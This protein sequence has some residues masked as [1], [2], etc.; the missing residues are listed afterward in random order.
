MESGFLDIQSEEVDV[1]LNK[2]KAEYQIVKDKSF[3]NLGLTMVAKLL[4]GSLKR[5]H[6]KIYLDIF[7]NKPKAISVLKDIIISKLLCPDNYFSYIIPCKDFH[8]LAVKSYL[9]ETNLKKINNSK[10]NLRIDH[11]QF[12]MYSILYQ[13]F[14]MHSKNII[15]RC[16]NPENIFVN[17]SEDFK[18]ANFENSV[19]GNEKRFKLKPS[20]YEVKFMAPEEFI[21]RKSIGK[22]SDIWSI[23]CVLLDLILRSSISSNDT[24]KHFH[25]VFNSQEDFD[26]YIVNQFDL[27]SLR[28]KNDDD[29]NHAKD[30]ALKILRFN[31]EER[32]TC[33]EVLR[34]QFFNKIHDDDEIL[35]LIDDKSI[36]CEYT[37]MKFDVRVLG[38]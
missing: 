14:Y 7:E 33:L 24:N 16:I 5:Y 22:A 11:V 20:L 6:L 15:H 25:E 18:L 19:I 26:I 9:Y 34:H 13:M 27:F 28:F 4:W 32:I 8:N 35:N 38:C 10:F 37:R 21:N 1:L 17:T 3:K 23:G 29:Y 12:F 30:L 36:S 31:P 2:I